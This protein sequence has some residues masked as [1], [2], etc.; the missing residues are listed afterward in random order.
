MPTSPYFPTY[1][2]GYSG[3]QSLVQDLVD[4]QIKLFGTDIYYLPRTLLKENTLDDV[5]YSKF[6]EQFQVEMI[7]QNVQGFGD[8]NEFINKFGLKLT[9]EVKFSVSSRRWNQ[10]AASFG[11]EARPLEGDLLFFPLTKDLYEIKYVRVEAVFHQFGKLQF[12]DITAELYEVGNEEIDTGIN[13]I[14]VIDRLLSPAINIVMAT[15]GAGNFTVGELVEGSVTGFKAK[16]TAWN[17]TTRTLTVI[18]RTGTFA[19]DEIIMGEDSNAAW[20]VL[21]F[22]TLEDPNI[23]Y[24]ENKY[25]ETEA[26]VILDFNEK[27]PFGEYGNIT[28]SF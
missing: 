3:E 21:S 8:N 17:S 11:L 18:D 25:I 28:G 6:E 13:D 10:S 15:G 26:N 19:E 20:D 2:Q 5:I 24:D 1:Y 9:D 7:L 12:Y 16:V 27:N 23:S 14:D 4:E 22:D